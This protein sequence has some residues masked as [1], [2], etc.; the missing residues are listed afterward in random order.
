MKYL[1]LHD[2]YIIQSLDM[3]H[4][5]KVAVVNVLRADFCQIS[6]LNVDDILILPDYARDLAAMFINTMFAQPTLPEG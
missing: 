4:P 5:L 1:L 2:L 6:N 3:L